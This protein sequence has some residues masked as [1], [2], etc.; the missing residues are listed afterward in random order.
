MLDIAMGGNPGIFISAF[1]LLNSTGFA[2]SIGRYAMSE[3]KATE[4]VPTI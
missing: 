3:R 1:V 2:A 4:E